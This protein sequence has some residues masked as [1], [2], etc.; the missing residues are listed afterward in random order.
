[1]KP[2][3]NL[4]RWISRYT[5]P[6]GLVLPVDEEE[7]TDEEEV[8]ETGVEEVEEAGEEEVEETG[9]EEVEEAGEEEVEETG[10]EEVEEVG[11]EEVEETGEEEGAEGTDE[12]MG[13]SVTSFDVEFLAF[14][15]EA[16][17]PRA[18]ASDTKSHPYA[19]IIL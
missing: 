15:Y 16:P 10:V 11:E 2:K 18:W 6:E 4:L 14:K 17:P 9:V 3:K 8:E 13:L 19:L 7:E 12:T 5:F 1:M